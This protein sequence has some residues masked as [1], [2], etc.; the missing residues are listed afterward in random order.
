MNLIVAP[1]RTKGLKAI[2][3]RGYFSSTQIKAYRDA[4]I[5]PCVANPAT[6]A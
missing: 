3:D 6:P 5:Q 4:G 1:P 2:A